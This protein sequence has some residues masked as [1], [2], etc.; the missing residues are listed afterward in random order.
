MIARSLQFIFLFSIALALC[1]AAPL[2]PGSI[3]HLSFHDVDGNTLSTA[4]GHVTIITVVTR[5]NEQQAHAVADQVPDFCLGNQKYRYVTLVIRQRLDSEAAK[6]RREYQ[7]KQIGHDPRKDMFVIADF[8]GS[9]V[10]QL[11]LAVDSNDVHVFVF[12]GRG[13]LVQHWTGVPP[14]DSLGKAIAATE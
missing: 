7:Q 3:N 11:G 2:Q 8:D 5:Q 4:D 9:A 13:K 1:A 12:N 14:N 10:S 6:L